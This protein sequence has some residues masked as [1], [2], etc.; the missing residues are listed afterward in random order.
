LRLLQQAGDR[1]G[2]PPS[3][4]PRS[5]QSNY[6]WK[7]PE[8]GI[9]H[10]RGETVWGCETGI[11]TLRVEGR[12][13]R[14]DEDGE[15]TIQYL[16]VDSLSAG[17]FDTGNMDGY[18][19]PRLKLRLHCAHSFVTGLVASE[20]C[21]SSAVTCEWDREFTIV[22]TNFFADISSS[23]LLDCRGMI[24][25]E[26]VVSWANLNLENKISLKYL[27]EKDTHI[28]ISRDSQPLPNGTTWR[29]THDVSIIDTD[30]DLSDWAD[31]GLCHYNYWR[32]R[33]TCTLETRRRNV[34]HRHAFRRR[35]VP[36]DEWVC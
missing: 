9:Q 25:V 17:L 4:I 26:L 24:T 13:T 33:W 19:P 15:Q 32:W 8:D 28:N 36:V 11:L 18:L 34:I 10:C 6:D 5:I 12:L 2:A 14:F 27:V 16:L 23:G 20:M 7:T 1:K 22:S 29:S 21:Q 30:N 35:A 31:S 3:R